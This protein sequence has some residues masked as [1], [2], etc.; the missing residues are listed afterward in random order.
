MLHRVK[1]KP[2]M[3]MKN[4]LPRNS[5]QLQSF[6]AVP[7]RAAFFVV[8]TL[9]QIPPILYTFEFTNTDTMKQTKPEGC[10][11]PTAIFF[12]IAFLVAY[13]LSSC[14]KEIELERGGDIFEPRIQFGIYADTAAK[15]YFKI[16]AASQQVTGVR[17]YS[18]VATKAP[19]ATNY[20][21][22]TFLADSLRPGT[23]NTNTGVVN[24]REGN[25]IL[26][27]ATAASFTVTITKNVDGLIQ[28]TF[29]GKLYDHNAGNEVEIFDGRIEDV[30]LI[31]R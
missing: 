8:E 25:R 13:L 20:F 14:S 4:N 5:I 22:L 31:Y 16:N 7:T 18:I 9:L 2:G 27:N 3:K 17:V 21:S 28:G 1:K 24:F 10:T 11:F 29:K 26:S 12:L 19:E 6:E 30:Q 15:T 23:Y